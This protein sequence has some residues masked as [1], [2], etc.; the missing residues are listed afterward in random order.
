MVYFAIGLAVI[1]AAAGI[2]FRWKVLLPVIVLLPLLAIIVSVSRGLTPRDIA[3]V[4]IVAEA[5][6]QG[7]YFLGLLIRLITTA[8]MRLARAST[9]FKNRHDPDRRANNRHAAPP[10]G[11]SKGS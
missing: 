4:V 8:G 6:L 1:G 2:A 9:F 7:G 10:A 3:I 11:A 5:V